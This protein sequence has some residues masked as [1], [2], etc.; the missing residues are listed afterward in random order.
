VC[1]C[2]S[3]IGASYPLPARPSCPCG[4]GVIEHVWVA[5]PVSPRRSSRPRVCTCGSS[6]SRVSMWVAAC[7]PVLTRVGT[8]ARVRVC[9]RWCTCACVRICAR[10]CACMLVRVRSWASGCA[11]V[12]ARVC[13]CTCALVRVCARVRVCASVRRSVVKGRDGIPAP[14][15]SV[16]LSSS[17]MA[18]EFDFAAWMEREFPMHG[19]DTTGNARGAGARGRADGDAGRRG[20][21]WD[22]AALGFTP[23]TFFTQPPATGTRGFP[24][25]PVHPL[26]FHHP[27]RP[28]V[29]GNFR[30][31]L[32]PLHFVHPAARVKKVKRVKGRLKSPRGRDEPDRAGVDGRCEG[33]S[34]K[35]AGCLWPAAG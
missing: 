1:V 31:T 5:V 16:G 2:V 27:D 10:W 13:A 4:P 3:F 19:T 23:F 32:H 26:H 21:P 17:R 35:S 25:Q 28:S 24:R 34:W 14:R 9:A 29:P 20:V 6:S 12:H 30:D 7:Q 11:G 22:L 8:C 18:E 33:P 15:R